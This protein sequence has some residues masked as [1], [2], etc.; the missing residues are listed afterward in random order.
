M[1]AFKAS[2]LKI[3]IQPSSCWAIFT[4]IHRVFRFSLCCFLHPS[5]FTSIA[6]GSRPTF[7]SADS[8]TQENWHQ[9]IFNFFYGKKLDF[10][11]FVLHV[12]L[13]IYFQANYLFI[14]GLTRHRRWRNR[15]KD[16]HG[17]MCFGRRRLFRNFASSSVCLRKENVFIFHFSLLISYYFPSIC[18][19]NW[20]IFLEKKGVGVNCTDSHPF[21]TLLSPR[22][23]I[24]YSL[25]AQRN[26]KKIWF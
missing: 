10:R 25:K 13:V 7:V 22:K 6:F 26:N 11:F 17:I 21:F 1:F 8:H 2:R 5:H 19:N 15:E 16:F 24:H 4:L 23:L 18:R 9:L 12:F 20:E 14:M 3:F